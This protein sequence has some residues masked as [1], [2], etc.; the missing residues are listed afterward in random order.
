MAKRSKALEDRLR[1][2]EAREK[3][4]GEELQAAGLSGEDLEYRCD[5]W[6]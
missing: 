3:R 4:A 5:S 1:L 2:T 6:M